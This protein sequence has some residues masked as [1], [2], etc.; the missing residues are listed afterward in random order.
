MKSEKK[1]KEKIIITDNSG[2]PEVFKKCLS[3]TT[4][5][6]T[7]RKLL[8]CLDRLHRSEERIRFEKMI[9]KYFS[10]ETRI[11]E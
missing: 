1:I 5:C 9:G 6:A 11:G 10:K 3:C 7:V 2:V 8:N 4:R